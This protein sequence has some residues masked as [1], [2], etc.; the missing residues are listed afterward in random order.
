MASS[1]TNPKDEFQNPKDRYQEYDGIT[2]TD[3]PD[4][5]PEQSREFANRGNK[6]DPG[7]VDPRA[8]YPEFDGI[9][10]GD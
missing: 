4:F 7:R 8:I 6:S 1:K 9:I 10:G 3:P 2:S 5:R